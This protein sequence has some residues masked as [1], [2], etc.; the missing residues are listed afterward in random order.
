M[1]FYYLNTGRFNDDPALEE[2]EAANLEDA[3]SEVAEQFREK[4]TRGLYDDLSYIFPYKI[5]QEQ[6]IID[7]NFFSK[8][9]IEKIKKINCEK[10]EKA[11]RENNE[12]NKERDYKKYLELKARFEPAKE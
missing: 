6:K 11:K 5:L 4:E 7:I 12:Y 1:K 10:L 2:V 8:E 9:E 3:I